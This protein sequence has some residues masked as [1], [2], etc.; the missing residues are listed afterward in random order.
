MR[1]KSLFVKKTLLLDL[2]YNSFIANKLQIKQGGNHYAK[3]NETDMLYIIILDNVFWYVNT[4][5]G[6]F[7][8]L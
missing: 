3:E 4:N 8:K 2:C 7:V 1:L 5:N 6:S